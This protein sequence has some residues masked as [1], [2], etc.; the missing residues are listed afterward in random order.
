M[1]RVKTV[2]HAVAVGL[3]FLQVLGILAR[4]PL[5]WPEP[6][7][8]QILDAANVANVQLSLFATDCTVKSFLVRYM[9]SLAL[10]LVLA[11]V[12]VMLVCAVKMVPGLMA[13]CIPRAAM[14][15]VPLQAVMERLVVVF[16][17]L[18]YIPLSRS[19]L[20]FF[21]CSQLPNNSYV[22]DADT[23]VQ[24]FGDEWLSVLPLALVGLVVYVAAMPVFFAVRLWRR[25]H[26]LD[27]PD[28]L[29]RLGSIYN[30]Y[31]RKWYWYEVAQL[32]K[33]L[34]FVSTALFF[35]NI[36]VWLFGGLIAVFGA[37]AVFVLKYK[38]FHLPKHNTL[39]MKL[40][41][42][43]LILVCSGMLF[44]LDD[45]SRGSFV[46]IVVIVVAT[47]AY[48][49]GSIITAGVHEIGE[50]IRD[51][52]RVSA[53]HPI[54]AAHDEA[55]VRHLA[56]HLPDV[57]SRSLRE[58]LGE[59]LPHSYYDSPNTSIALA[60]VDATMRVDHDSMSS[61]SRSGSDWGSS[62]RSESRN[63]SSKS[64]PSPATSNDSPSESLVCS[65]SVDLSDMPHSAVLSTRMSNR[66]G[67]GGDGSRSSL[68]GS[69]TRNQSHVGQRR[70]SRR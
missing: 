48:A 22:L 68:R 57:R 43:V 26:R 42:C 35:S 46:A 32:I 14:T 70:N 27:D 37:S 63:L 55:L 45:H 6:P 54:N 4:A 10:P 33:R 8:Q 17:P 25:R 18:V 44:V 47:M 66:S 69:K 19:V 15:H 16:G 41:V 7:V 49:L 11:V 28:V 64:G 21:D 24:C 30:I 23:S 29:L 34:G 31:L 36:L 13:C 65:A 39:E 38:P 59:V 51:R 67:M 2:P 5:N 62:T 56:M 58:Q 50:R 1:S 61:S 40:D 60:P 9:M 3:V 53:A 12:L 52:H 20:V